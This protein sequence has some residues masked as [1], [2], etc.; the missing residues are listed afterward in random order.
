MFFH[1]R[2]SDQKCNFF[3]MDI[4]LHIMPESTSA[5][6]AYGINCEALVFDGDKWFELENFKSTSGAIKAPHLP[7]S[8]E[9]FA[10]AFAVLDKEDGSV[11]VSTME[12]WDMICFVWISSMIVKMKNKE[13]IKVMNGKFKI[14]QHLVDAAQNDRKDFL[15]MATT[16][17]V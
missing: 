16:M 15:M 10:K 17:Y 13:K 11:M 14:S 1:A 5:D 6:I 12:K 9:T 4:Q 3:L 8:D 7:F 2:A